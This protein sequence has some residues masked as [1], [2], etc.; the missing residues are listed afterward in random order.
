MNLKEAQNVAEKFSLNRLDI[1]LLEIRGAL[2]TL[3]NFYEDYRHL[4]TKD[5]PDHP[6]YTDPFIDND[7]PNYN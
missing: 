7:N 6:D 1:T 2:V 5:D 3:A 4:L